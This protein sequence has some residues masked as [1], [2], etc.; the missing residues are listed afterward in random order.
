MIFVSGEQL[1]EA[2]SM[3]DAVQAVQDA[4]IRASRREA[5]QPARLVL[6]DG[7]ALTM[8]ARG[9]DTSGT[10]VKVVSVYPENRS[11][12]LPTVHALAV[13][14]DAATGE[15][16]LVIDGAALTALRTGAA[17]GVATDLL[18]SKGAR[19]LAV[20]G[21]GA[22]APDQVRGVCAVRDIDQVRLISRS[23]ASAFALA[24][25]LAD[26]IP[27]VAFSISAAV[28]EAVA[29]ADVVCCATTAVDP[30]LS[31]SENLGRLHIN[32]IGSYRRGMKELGVDLLVRAA[33][34]VVDEVNAA[35]TEAGEIIDALATGV[36]SASSLIEIGTLALGPPSSVEGVTLFKSVGIALQD[37]AVAHLLS[38]RLAQLDG[39]PVSPVRANAE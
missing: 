16:S 31:W 27:G 9:S 5:E 8:M 37:W 11:V 39:K 25:Q 24:E 13:W 38:Y 19:V 22:Q 2:V 15:P 17:S 6:Q 36:I 3:E 21:A 35:C 23:G 33:L 4:F 7:T 18:A 32:A 12:G 1:R 28:D 34:I 26:E 20:I 10:V 14:L 30:V 29:G